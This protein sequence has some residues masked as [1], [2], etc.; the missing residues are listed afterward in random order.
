MAL[1]RNITRITKNHKVQGE[2]ECFAS[3]SID[4][5][6]NRYLQL[7][8]TGAPSKKEKGAVDQSIRLDEHAASLLKQLIEETFTNLE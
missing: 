8:T 3:D 4:K 7:D 1:V 6:G 5:E 2:V